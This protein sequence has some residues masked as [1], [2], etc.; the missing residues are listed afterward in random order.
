MQVIQVEPFHQPKMVEKIA[1]VYQETFGGP[2]WNEGYKCPV[3]EK[4]FP[5]SNTETLCS[6]CLD[7]T[8]KSVL[9]I[10]YWPKSK[11]ISD[12]YHEMSNPEPLCLLMQGEEDAIV[13]FVWGYQM[14]VDKNTDD[15]LEAPGLHQL[16]GNRTFFY[17]DEAAVLPAFQGKGIGGILIR[18]IFQRQRQKNI[19]LRTLGNS[20][21]FGLTKKMGGETIL[22]ISRER[23]IMALN[24]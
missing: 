14:T 24:F 6:P 22:S 12:F 5:L 20:Q 19:L 15:Y 17:L 7:S 3:C 21:M 1:A 8:N 2:P 11:I 10:E 23:V 13:G 18:Q 9:L 4:V 16:V